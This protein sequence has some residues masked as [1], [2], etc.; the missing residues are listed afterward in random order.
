MADVARVR[1]LLD[2]G[3]DPWSRAAPLHLTASALVVDPGTGRVLLRWH[4]RQQMWL[5]VGGHADPGEADPLAI[6]LREAAEETGLADLRP[7]PDDRIWHVAI[8]QVAAGKGEPAHEHADLRYLLSTGDPAAVRPESPGAPLRWLT[9]GEA[10]TVVG[11]NNLRVTLDRVEQALLEGRAPLGG[12]LERPPLERL[13]DGVLLVKRH[14]FRHG[15][16]RQCAGRVV[17]VSGPVK[18]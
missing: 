11:T 12:Q 16:S 8:C 18:I 10:R 1:A 15:V 17:V 6:A 14:E 9:L 7:W 3:S 5:Q 4:K 13:L 2:A